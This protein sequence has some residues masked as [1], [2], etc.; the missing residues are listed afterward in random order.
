M[1]DKCKMM[2][3]LFKFAVGSY[4]V[5]IDY[6]EYQFS[7]GEATP[8][9]DTATEDG[10]GRYLRITRQNYTGGQLIYEYAI[11]MS[12]GDPTIIRPE[13]SKEEKIAELEKQLAD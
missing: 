7:W 10:V 8:S 12:V 4:T 3:E 9:W 13:K 11:S 6:E 2:E 1:L 5:E